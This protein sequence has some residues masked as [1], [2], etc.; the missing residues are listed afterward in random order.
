VAEGGGLL[1]LPGVT[2][3]GPKL[4]IS[5]PLFVGFLVGVGCRRMVVGRC[6]GT[7]E[8][9]PLCA[10]WAHVDGGVASDCRD[11]AGLQCVALQLQCTHW[12]APSWTI[13]SPSVCPHRWVVRSGEHPAAW[14]VG[15]RTSSAWRSRHSSREHRQPTVNPPTAWSTSSAR[16]RRESRTWRNDIVI[17]F[18]R[19]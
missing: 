17:T 12:R 6:L 14:D 18:S 5:G 7:L 8:P 2:R 10:S 15:L 19:R 1:R 16:C 11:L 9:M 13:R 3:T 4:A